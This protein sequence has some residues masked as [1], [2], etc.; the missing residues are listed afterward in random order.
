MNL[1]FEDR[2]SERIKIAQEL[3]DTLLQGVISASMLLHVAADELPP[4]SLSKRK[5]T[6]VLALMSDVMEEGRRALRGLRGQQNSSSD[7]DQA[8]KRMREELAMDESIEFRVAEEGRR[9]QLHP[10]V[11]DDVYRIGRE[12]L[13][14]AY[15]HSGAKAIEVEM[16]Y[17]TRFFSVF[18]RD[19]GCGIRPDVLRS[20]PE[21]HWGLIGM[22]ERAEKIGGHL[23]IWTR[24]AGGTEIRLCI[25]NQIAF[26]DY[27]SSHFWEKLAGFCSPKS[28]DNELL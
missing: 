27:H 2:L 17:G 8:F 10:T 21:G 1:R 9:R 12:A 14:N 24:K 26:E 20:G 5:L 18:V 22:R 3:H 16:E 7:L 4:E 28:N 6:R 11:R 23:N 15:R 25:P 13:V 19:D